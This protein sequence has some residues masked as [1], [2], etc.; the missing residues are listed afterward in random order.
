MQKLIQK[1]LLTDSFQ[2]AGTIIHKLGGMIQNA[3]AM[4]ASDVEELKDI[5]YRMIRK[6]ND[7]GSEI[8]IITGV[9]IRKISDHE[10]SK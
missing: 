3:E 9:D 6:Y 2:R 10:C 4:N 7:M 5:Y 8:K 1:E